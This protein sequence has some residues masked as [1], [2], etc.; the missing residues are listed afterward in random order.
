MPTIR[1]ADV[2]DFEYL[3]E[4]DRHVSG[5]MLMGKIK[6]EEILVLRETDVMVGWLRFGYF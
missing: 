6:S 3:S 5:E 1:Y 2:G 4:A